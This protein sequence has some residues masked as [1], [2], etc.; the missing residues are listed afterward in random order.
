LTVQRS[1]RV[2]SKSPGNIKLI[3]TAK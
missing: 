1:Y 3:A 2:S